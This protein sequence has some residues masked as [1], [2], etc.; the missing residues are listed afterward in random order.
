DVDED[1]EIPKDA[2]FTC[3]PNFGGSEGIYL[4][5]AMHSK[6]NVS[7]F[8]TGKTLEVG[9]ASFIK[10]GDISTECNLMLNGNGWEFERPTP[11][12]EKTQ[13]EKKAEKISKDKIIGN[14]NYK[15]IPDKKYRKVSKEF[16][17]EIASR[18]D[19][20]NIKY[21]GKMNDD[22]TITFTFGGAQKDCAAV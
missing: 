21:S 22:D 1:M 12:P 4:D 10:M 11:T 9:Y 8:I 3:H 5:I 16:A 20:A 7:R 13:P 6:G 18:F 17:D 14:T 15:Y 19:A 2:E